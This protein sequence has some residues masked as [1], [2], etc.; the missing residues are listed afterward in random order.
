[1][2]NS[3]EQLENIESN[4]KL[5]ELNKQIND[6]LK[7]SAK[8]FNKNFQDLEL[9]DETRY[10]ISNHSSNLFSKN[11]EKSR[12]YRQTG[13]D[14]YSEKRYEEALNSYNQVN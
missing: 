3:S 13:N 12:K 9:R 7:E 14:F 11:L 6:D 4:K 5:N 10:R 2:T 8:E 1:M